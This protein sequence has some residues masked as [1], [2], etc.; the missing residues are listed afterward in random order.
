MSLRQ[1]DNLTP[2]P[3]VTMDLK[4]EEFENNFLVTCIYNYSDTH[5]EI[6]AERLK[7]HTLLCSYKSVKNMETK[8]EIDS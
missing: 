6:T 7:R 3:L 8:K 2:P 1:F 4:Q 5:I